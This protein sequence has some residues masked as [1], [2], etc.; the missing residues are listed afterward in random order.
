MIEM[1]DYLMARGF[2]SHPFNT[3]DADREKNLKRFVVLPPYFES[4]FGI[5]ED[6][7]PFLVLG[8]RGLGKTTLKCMIQDRIR[9]QYHGKIASV[10]YSQFPFIQ[11]KEI[12]EVTLLDHLLSLMRLISKEACELASK[13][14]EKFRSLK[15]ETKEILFHLAEIY[16][17]DAERGLYYPKFLSFTEK[18]MHS[19]PRKKGRDFYLSDSTPLELVVEKGDYTLKKTADLLRDLG[20]MACYVFIDKLDET[21]RTMKEPETAGLLAG[22][23]ISCLEILQRD[24]F[25]FQFFVPAESIPNLKRSGFRNDKVQNQVITWNEEK[26]AEV[27]RKRIIAFNKDGKLFGKLGNLC[28]PEIRDKIDEFIIKKSLSS[29]RNLLRFC[30]AIFSEH[31]ESAR[32]IDDCITR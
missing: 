8:M 20:Y 18:L 3:F 25:S 2:S 12:Q 4:V 15:A 1:R 13:D 19:Y 11:H 24:F 27:L 10:D 30:N 22:P 16:L 31:M 23:L 5:P 6:P 7:Q 14:I 29:P 32:E 17:G 21:T 28:E 9:E 26:L